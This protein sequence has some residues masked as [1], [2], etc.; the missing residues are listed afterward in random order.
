MFAF[1]LYNLVRSESHSYINPPDQTMSDPVQ[2]S[3]SPDIYYI[4]LDGYG[5]ADMLEEIYGFSNHDFTNFLT[6]R[7]F[8]VAD[9]SQ[10]NYLH[11]AVSL[12]SSMNMSYIRELPGTFIRTPI[13]RKLISDSRVRSFL[14]KR[15]YQFIAFSTPFYYS[16]I[17]NADKF[18]S[19]KKDNTHIWFLGSMIIPSSL[20]TI[21]LEE[22]RISQ[23][24]SYRDQ[25]EQILYM[26]DQLGKIPE[27]PGPK[28]IFAHI[29]APHPAY[30]FDEN[31]PVTPDKPYTLEFDGTP[32]ESLEGYIG[33]VI[34][35]NQIMEKT[36]D[37]ILENSNVPPI[38]IIQGDHGPNT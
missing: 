16:D 7:G 11:T 38:I 13:I 12:T 18:L 26:A 10:S 29:V 35:L 5:R 24:G 20:A 32:E 1:G 23:S 17:T 21:L 27:F 25:Q 8:T 6:S 4:I 30:I 31:G 28:F 15:G 14:E 37:T 34:Y 3:N 19:L 22:G 36:I 2:P 9:R 33:Q